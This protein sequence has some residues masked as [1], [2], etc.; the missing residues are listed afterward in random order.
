MYCA[1][2]ACK[3]GVNIASSRYR[4]TVAQLVVA[5]FV[6]KQ[7]YSVFV[8]FSVLKMAINDKLVFEVQSNG[9][10]EI[11]KS[12]ES[13]HQVFLRF[14]NCTSRTVDVSW[15]DFEGKKRL[16]TFL[17]P[18][19]SYDINTYV[20]HPWEFTDRLVKKEHYMINN[21][22]IFRAPANLGG[23]RYRTNWNI[24]V[25]MRTLRQSAMIRV[26]SLVPSLNRV[27]ELELPYVLE[28]EV[29][30]MINDMSTW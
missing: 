18:G 13:I 8:S 30:E 28:D 20:T 15:R 1:T 12:K 29:K 25:G 3:C 19:M 9:E 6:P 11:V 4:R 10:R 2:R 21:S 14:T 23:M 5:Y 7:T 27:H 24:T 22:T 26:A 17:E 16:Y